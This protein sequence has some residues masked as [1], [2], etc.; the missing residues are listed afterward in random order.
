M[1]LVASNRIGVERGESG[2]IT[3][4]GSSFIA[5]ADDEKIVECDRDGQ[6]IVT[7]EFVLD[8][9]AYRRRSWGVFRGRR[10]TC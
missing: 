6:V 3:F 10:P 7:A 5:G 8:A 2:E 4:Y 9:L 1:P